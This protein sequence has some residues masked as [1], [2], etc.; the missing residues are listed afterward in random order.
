VSYPPAMKPM[1]P[2]RETEVAS[3]AVAMF[4]IGALARGGFDWEIQ[5]WVL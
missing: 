1:P 3:G 5:G 4:S 2:A